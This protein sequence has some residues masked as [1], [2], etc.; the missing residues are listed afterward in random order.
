MGVGSL[1][2]WATSVALT[3][4]SGALMML[5]GY[6][7]YTGSWAAGVLI[8]IPGGIVIMAAFA[9]AVRADQI[10]RDGAADGPR[11]LNGSA[12][13]AAILL[14]GVVMFIAGCAIAVWGWTAAL[15]L[16]TVGGLIVSATFALSRG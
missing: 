1:R 13:I 3:L 11:R 6:V 14:S 7:A 15:A 5:A 10:A 9:A 4:A 2:L 12:A 8:T 16:A